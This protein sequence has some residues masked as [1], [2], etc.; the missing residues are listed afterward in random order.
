MQD[1]HPTQSSLSSPDGNP[2]SGA[3]SNPQVLQSAYTRGFEGAIARVT[4]L[5]KA[6]VESS[7]VDL[8]TL[9][10][11]TGEMISATRYE[12]DRILSQA[13][14]TARNERLLDIDGQ[15]EWRSNQTWGYGREAISHGICAIR[16]PA[17]RARVG[18]GYDPSTPA[19]KYPSTVETHSASIRA[20]SSA[21][22]AD[23]DSPQS[24]ALNRRIAA[25]IIRA[26]CSD[27]RAAIDASSR[28]LRAAT[29]DC[30]QARE[31]ARTTGQSRSRRRF[32]G[33]KSL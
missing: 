28:L 22:A 10:P 5:A 7:H 18:Y 31:F 2:I 1:S 4:A 15:T 21:I 14:D 26:E 13:V 25:A 30:R 8:D 9:V 3:P 27:I 33:P 6:R 19:A 16:G 24:M 17:A 32:K 20:D 11:D 23:H 29:A 12:A